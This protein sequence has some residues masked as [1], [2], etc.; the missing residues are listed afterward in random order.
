MEDNIGNDLEENIFGNLVCFEDG[1]ENHDSDV[2]DESIQ[3]NCVQIETQNGN[4]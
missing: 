4:K 1:R 2:C 3:I